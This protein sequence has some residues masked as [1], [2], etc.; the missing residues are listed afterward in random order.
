[1]GTAFAKRDDAPAQE[2][3]L[4]R[5]LDE[6]RLLS[7]Q[8]RLLALNAGLESVAVR[9]VAGDATEAETDVSRAASEADRVAAA[10]ELLLQQIRSAS[11]LSDPL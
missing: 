5:I 4:R 10:V 11:A 8:S 7:A 1:M 3:A 6:A 9:Q 2:I